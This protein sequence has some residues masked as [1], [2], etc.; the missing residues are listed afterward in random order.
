MCLKEKGFSSGVL[1]AQR[2]LSKLCQALPLS[3]AALSLARALRDQFGNCLTLCTIFFNGLF[4]LWKKDAG[5]C[6]RE[7]TTGMGGWQGLKNV[8]RQLRGALSHKEAATNIAQIDLKKKIGFVLKHN[9]T[10][11]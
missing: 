9:T 7:L 5:K 11:N 3:R 1:L 10:L 2:F 8:R 6:Q 4:L